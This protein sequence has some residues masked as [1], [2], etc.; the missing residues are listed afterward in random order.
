M[1]KQYT[2]DDLGILVAGDWSLVNS[3]GAEAKPGVGVRATQR[4]KRG[5]WNYP[6]EMVLTFPFSLNQF[7][8]FCDWHTYFQWEVIETK[9]LNDDGS[10]DED[11]LAELAQRGED[12]AEL[13]RRYLTGETDA[14]KEAG[15]LPTV[16]HA[17]APAAQPA[18]QQDAPGSN[19]DTAQTERDTEAAYRQKRRN[20]LSPVIEK[21][22]RQSGN[23]YDT[24]SVWLE[25]VKMAQAQ[26]SPLIGVTE[27]GIK[28]A[29]GN[30]EL[31]YLSVK[32][33]RDRLKRELKQKPEAE[34]ATTR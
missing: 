29:D 26:E 19:G 10:L 15:P 27:D 25:L 34:R 9:Y 17:D 11:A 22:Q 30:D 6:R 31:K 8:D 32:N 24:A 13:V 5:P 16:N 3:E 2:E 4:E 33:L 23:R 20:L 21:A 14:E 7:R 12:A 1:A 28:W 18:G